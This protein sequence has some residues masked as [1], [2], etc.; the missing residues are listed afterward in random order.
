M[1]AF[2]WR[3]ASACI[4]NNYT[5]ALQH[6]APGAMSE[7][8]ARVLDGEGEGASPSEQQD[9]TLAAVEL[10]ASPALYG[11]RRAAGCGTQ[12]RMLLH[13]DRGGDAAHELHA[14]AAESELARQRAEAEAQ[15]KANRLRVAQEQL[16]EWAQQKEADALDLLLAAEQAAAAAASTAG[17]N[18][19]LLQQ[20]QALR[21]MVAEAA[22]EAKAFAAQQKADVESLKRSSRQVGARFST[23]LARSGGR[24]HPTAAASWF[25][26]GAHQ[27]CLLHAGQPPRKQWRCG[28]EA[29]ARG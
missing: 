22:A 3:I 26:L 10:E 17:S 23:C 6:R 15:D 12:R 2:L 27:A 20:V 7:R 29:A 14:C 25:G 4:P 16:C 24:S 19:M 5:S 18:E 13:G 11:E 21:N 28:D 8:L 1:Q 9:S